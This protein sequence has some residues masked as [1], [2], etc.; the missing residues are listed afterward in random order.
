MTTDYRWGR[1]AQ[2]AGQGAAVDLADIAS[3]STLS[4]STSG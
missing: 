2:A 1:P 3:T 4:V